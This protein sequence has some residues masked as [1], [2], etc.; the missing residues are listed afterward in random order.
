M[1]RQGT[2][3]L[4]QARRAKQQAQTCS[5]EQ[6]GVLLSIGDAYELLACLAQIQERLDTKTAV[7]VSPSVH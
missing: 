5:V 7:Y 2:E 4:R 6:R 3:F 1:S